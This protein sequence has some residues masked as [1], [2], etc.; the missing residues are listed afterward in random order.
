MATGT[1]PLIIDTPSP[2]QAGIIQYQPNFRHSS[3]LQSSSSSH[4]LS[5]TSLHQEVMKDRIRKE[6]KGST[7]LVDLSA[8]GAPFYAH[9]D[10]I[11]AVLGRLSNHYGFTD[12]TLLSDEDSS[13]DSPRFPPGGFQGTSYRPLVHFLNAIVNATNDCLPPSPRYLSDLHFDHHGWE[14]EEAYTT[15]SH[16]PLSPEVLGLLRSPTSQRQKVSWNDVAIIVE[17]ND[18]IPELIVQLSTYARSYL[19]VDRRRSFAP[20]IGF[21]HKTL[22]IF[23]FAFHRSGL[24]S[25]GPISLRTPEG[26]ESLVKYMVGILS[27]RDEEGFGLDMTRIGNVFR[28][29]ERDYDIARPIWVRKSVCG[30]ATAVYSLKCTRLPI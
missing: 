1:D 5:D 19:T 8:E 30:R 15:N 24:S 9:P 23:F 11:Q 21:N 3:P 7:F 13:V 17:A 12:A 4:S 16:Q 14:M 26:F 25:S 27:I 10:S 20:A 29:N 2:V 28:I 22:E 6:F 18:H